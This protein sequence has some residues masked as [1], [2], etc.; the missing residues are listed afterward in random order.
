[1]KFEKLIRLLSL[2]L[3]VLMMGG[4][5]AIFASCGG[6][7]EEEESTSSAMAD[8]DD[9]D[10]N[11]YQQLER[12]NYGKILKVNTIAGCETDFLPDEDQ[13]GEILTDELI[14]RNFRLKEDYGVEFAYQDNAGY[15]ELISS[16]QKQIQGNLDDYDLYDGQLHNFINNALQNHCI[17]LNDVEYVD[18]YQPWWDENCREALL[19][20][21]NNF[22]MTG[23]I[24]ASVMLASSCMVF[25]KELMSD[26]KKDEPYDLVYDGL[27]TM[28]ALYTYID[29]VTNPNALEGVGRYGLSGWS[30]HAGYSLFYS[31]GD[32]F[33]KFEEGVPVLDFNNQKVINI[34]EKMYKILVT[35]QS[36]YVT[37]SEYD[38][39]ES[40]DQ[41]F[42]DG[43]ALFLCGDLGLVSNSLTAME[44]DYGVVPMPKYDSMQESYSS[45]INGGAPLFFIAT[46]E[47]DPGFV[48]HIMEAMATYNYEYIADQIVDVIAKSKD[49]RDPESADMVDYIM[50]SRVYDF[51]Y[52]TLLDVV[53]VVIKSLDEDKS[54]IASQL[55]SARKA[56]D[57]SL[58]SILRS[59]ER[60]K[61]K[62]N[63]N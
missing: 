36:D 59:W 34:Y 14:A 51:A 62:E 49:I 53:Q 13:K 46:T 57:K 10:T 52:Y 20:D 37:G 38:D 56:S 16:M 43:R 55:T 19:I 23:N 33:V 8:L 40:L 63:K 1:M 61:D 54:T 28:D 44:D 7:G 2:L 41:I 27:W 29:G 47:K 60:I 17:D 11:A 18:L 32:T 21:G 58:S 24:S 12:V 39:I 4:C 45:F 26:L 48:G 31:A 35:A 22:M 50:A 42:K 6:E 15:V 9:T 25:N 3:A 5:M 30:L